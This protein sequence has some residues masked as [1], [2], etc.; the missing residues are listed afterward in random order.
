[1]SVCLH[2]RIE[3][4]FPNKKGV[5]LANNDRCDCRWSDFLLMRWRK[6]A[7]CVYRWR[8]CIVIVDKNQKAAQPSFTRWKSYS[9]GHYVSA[10]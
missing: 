7:M 10:D 8:K 5:C 4:K 2:A 3:S 9:L 6:I 1:M